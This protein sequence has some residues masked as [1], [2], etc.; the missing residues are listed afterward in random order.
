MSLQ[1]QSGRWSTRKRK[2]HIES[3]HRK[4]FQRENSSARF[5]QNWAKL[6]KWWQS[7]M[8]PH[9]GTKRRTSRRRRDKGVMRI[10]RRDNNG[11]EKFDEYPDMSCVRA[12]GATKWHAIHTGLSRD[13]VQI[14]LLWL[15]RPP[16]GKRLWWRI[17]HRSRRKYWLWLLKGCEWN[18]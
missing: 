16:D 13:R 12:S 3:W 7:P 18:V 8:F 15:L 9:C 11:K 1:G 5:L 2:N 4:R 17:L 10:E 6:E 14:S